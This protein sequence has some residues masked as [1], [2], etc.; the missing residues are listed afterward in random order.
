MAQGTS[1]ADA[2]LI[3]NVTTIADIQTVL[4]RIVCRLDAIEHEVPMNA[5]GAEQ[6]LAAIL[7]D[8]R[9]RQFAPPQS[10]QQKSIDLIDV[11]A[12]SPATFGGTRVR[13]SLPIPWTA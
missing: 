10:S 13:P 6:Q 5:G 7:V 4:H 12:M 1:A 9:T 8:V 11:K 3:D 2:V